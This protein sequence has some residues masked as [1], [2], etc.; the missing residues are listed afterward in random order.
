MCTW[1]RICWVMTLVLELSPASAWAQSHHHHCGHMGMG[2]GAVSGAGIGF[3]LPFYG[4]VGYDG[5]PFT[6]APMVMPGAFLPGFGPRLGN[7]PPAFGAGLGVAGPLPGTVPPPPRWPA[8]GNGTK[9]KKTDPTRSGQL[10][11]I[12]DRLFRAGNLH[13]A[14]ERYEQA[15][16]ADSGASSPRVRLAQVALARGQYAEAADRYREAMAAE[17]GWLANAPDIQ[18]IYG[19]PGDFHKQINRLETHLQAQPG[20]RDAW[21]VLGAQWYL[22]GQTNKAADIFLRLSDRKS[23][24]TL[25]AFLDAATPRRLGPQ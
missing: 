1:K 24:S 12:G 22:S 23:D 19:E 4:G 17:P 11:T 5:L 2:L 21:F 18:S 10:V 14:A 3:G 16:N 7:G 9:P 8:A 13:R 15:M 6:Y 25:A 20:D